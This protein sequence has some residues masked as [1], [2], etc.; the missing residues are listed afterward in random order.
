[1]EKEVFLCR[2]DKDHYCVRC[3]EFRGCCKFGYLEDGKRGCL[4]YEGRTEFCKTFNCIPSEFNS[5]DIEKL[6]RII[7]GFPKGEFNIQDAFDR[8]KA[9][10]T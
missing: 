7:R 10:R 5:E 2:P 3:C 1:M 4:D 8:L 9:E 6:R